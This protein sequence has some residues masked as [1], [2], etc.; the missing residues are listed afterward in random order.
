ME[1]VICTKE[2]I[3]AIRE[4]T[5]VTT[6]LT[7]DEILDAVPGVFMKAEIRQEAAVGI[8]VGIS[9]EIDSEEVE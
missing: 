5:G 2:K 6:P 9:A 7:L 3:T 8:S 1:R 4:K